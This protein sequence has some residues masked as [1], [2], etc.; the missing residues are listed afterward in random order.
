MLII[1][2]VVN[3]SAAMTNIDSLNRMFLFPLSIFQTNWRQMGIR[4]CS[5]FCSGL[6][7]LSVCLAGLSAL[8][9]VTLAA[10]ASLP[11]VEAIA[12]P[13]DSA[14]IAAGK[15]DQFAQAYLQVLKLL[16]DREPELP[17]AETSAE[18]LKVQQS[19]EAEAIELIK[20]FGLA[21]SEY[22]EMLSLASQDEAFRAKVLGRMD[23]SL[24]E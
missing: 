16:S 4:F 21:I 20:G 5:V 18:A 8:P 1:T 19:I 2:S 11:I 3:L 13:T 24:Q 10:S 23:K 15:V 9:A 14:D 7:A 12:S 17:A 22:M 6:L